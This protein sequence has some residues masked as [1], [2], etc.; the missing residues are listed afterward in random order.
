FHPAKLKRLERDHAA[1]T[2]RE[3][4]DAA[5]RRISNISLDLIFAVPDETLAVWHADL[6]ETLK[7]EPEH[8][9]TYGLTY[10]R[11]ARFW[12][13][14]ERGELIPA[15]E[16]LERRMYEEAIEQLTGAG[17]E[18]YE[19]SNFARPGGRCRHNEVYWS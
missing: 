13:S 15:E 10:E 12:G 9:S 17:L 8:V 5:R 19:V 1:D 6:H 16:E 18:H 3:A 14:R 11:G 4:V 7:V 2:I